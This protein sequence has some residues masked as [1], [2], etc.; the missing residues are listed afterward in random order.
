MIDQHFNLA[1]AQRAHGQ[2][3]CKYGQYL[4]RTDPLAD[5]VVAA[6]SQLSSGKGNR[7]L[8]TAL[9]E[10]IAAVPDAPAAL[11]RLFEQLDDVPFWVDWDE[12]DR[13][14]AAFL[15]SGLLGAAVIALYSLPLSYRSPSGNKPLIFSGQ[16]T[17]R[18]GRRMGETARFVMATCQPG[19][20]RRFSDGFKI[21]VKVRLM[22]AQ[23]RRLLLRSGRWD[24]DAWGAPINQCYLA[25]TN[26]LF[27][28]KL[29]AGLRRLGYR[30]SRAESEAL[31]QLWRYSGYLSGIEP[32]LLCVTEQEALRLANLI[33]LVDKPPDQDSLSLVKALLEVPI[34]PQQWKGARWSTDIAFGLSRALLGEEIADQLRLPKTPWRFVVPAMRPLVLAGDLARRRIPAG[35]G[36]AD[37]LGMRMWQWGADNQLA[38]IPAS[39]HLPEHLA[40]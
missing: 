37:R 25:G 14:G 11:H 35:Q 15:R 28:A 27:S 9:D 6:F 40:Q 32:E 10:G 2:R 22:H 34:V 19:G 39:F 8:D 12:L 13:G 21:T 18:A 7:M 24:M 23:V 36:L 26:L 3:A 16:L 20:L 33:A 29:S 4:H 31:M 17:R 30:H 1:A 5:D 38:G